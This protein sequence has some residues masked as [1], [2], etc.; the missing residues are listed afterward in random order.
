MILPTQ[1]KLLI[2]LTLITSKGFAFHLDR[3]HASMQ[4]GGYVS[5][6]GK[7]QTI[8]IRDVIGDQ[9]SVTEQKGNNGLV[10]FAYLLDGPSNAV[11]Q[12]AYGVD[13]FYFPGMNF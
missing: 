3:A 9:Y 11:L 4:L 13:V 7:A 12:L 8:F 1:F 5:S 6:Q 10:G 2:V